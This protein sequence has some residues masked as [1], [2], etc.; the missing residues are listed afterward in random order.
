LGACWV[1]GDKKPYANEVAKILEV[2]SSLKL[3]SLISLGWPKDK[4]IQNKKRGLKE[5]MHWEKF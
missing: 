3:V 1:A 2:P 5:V 4:I